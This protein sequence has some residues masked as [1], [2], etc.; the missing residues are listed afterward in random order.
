MTNES[1]MKKVFD[2]GFDPSK[3]KKIRLFNNLRKQIDFDPF[4]NFCFETV[5]EIGKLFFFVL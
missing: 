4:K 1:Y 5:E 2:V 3:S